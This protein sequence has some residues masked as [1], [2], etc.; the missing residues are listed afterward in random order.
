MQQ[1]IRI[2]TF[3]LFLV[4]IYYLRVS[5]KPEIKPVFSFPSKIRELPINKVIKYMKYIKYIKYHF[6]SQRLKTK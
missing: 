1:Q 6:I 3:F 2:N 4:K 5:R